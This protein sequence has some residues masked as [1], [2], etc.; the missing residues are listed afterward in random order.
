MKFYIF[1]QIMSSSYSPVLSSSIL[2]EK[3]MKILIEEY[4]E[5]FNLII[6]HSILNKKKPYLN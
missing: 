5:K 3:I 1:N 4:I 6:I 2:T